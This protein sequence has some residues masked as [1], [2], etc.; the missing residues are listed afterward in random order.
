MSRLPD[1]TFNKRT[2]RRK[3]LRWPLV[4]WV[5]EEKRTDRANVI[6]AI[7]RSAKDA[8]TWTPVVTNGEYEGKDWQKKGM[9]NVSFEISDIYVKSWRHRL[10]AM[11]PYPS[12]SKKKIKELIKRLGESQ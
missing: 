9:D 1:S 3:V 10:T 6:L 2:G 5:W 11:P 4:V 8:M 12:I 7:F